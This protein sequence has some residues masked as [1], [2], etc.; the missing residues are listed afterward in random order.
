MGG[1]CYGGG[2]CGRRVLG[3]GVMGE[4]V[5]GD[6]VVGGGDGVMDNT[7]EPTNIFRSDFWG[8]SPLSLSN[9]L[10][11]LSQ[12]NVHVHV[13]LFLLLV[14]SPLVVM[15]TSSSIT[16]TGGLSSPAGGPQTMIFN[17]QAGATD[18]TSDCCDCNQ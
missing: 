7:S 3:D 15:A 5:G 6:G 2:C 16:V 11:L 10:F 1:G 14:L 18:D 9:L 13:Y 8:F 17:V 4:G 12:L